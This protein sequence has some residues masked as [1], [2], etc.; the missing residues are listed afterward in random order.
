[1]TDTTV[2]VRPLTATMAN[3]LDYVIN[4]RGADIY[5]GWTP[6]GSHTRYA[7]IKGLADRG[8]LIAHMNRGFGGEWLVDVTEEGLEFAIANLD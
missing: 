1:M 6:V 3:L 4:S 2:A 7:T 8:L 5:E